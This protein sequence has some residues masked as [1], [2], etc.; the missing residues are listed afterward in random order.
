MEKYEEDYIERLFVAR[1]QGWILAFTAGGHC[2]FLPVLE[3]PESGRASRGQSVYSLLAGADRKDPIVAMLPVGDLTEEEKV[4]VFL[5][6][7]GIIKRTALSEFSNPRS[8]GIIAAGLKEDDRVLDVDLSDGGADVMLL[9]SS[10]R[11]IRFS[12]EDV[13]VQGRTAQGVKGIGLGDDDEAVGM[14]LI[15]REAAVLTVTQDGMGK[16][17][18]VSEFPLQRRGGT[19]T[20]ALPSGGKGSRVVSALEVLPQEEVM[21]ITAGGQVTRVK[22]NDVPVQG[23]RTQGRRMVK[24]KSG[25]RVA[26]VTRAAGDDSPGGGGPG[27]EGRGT[28]AGPDEYAG[29]EEQRELDLLEG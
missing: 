18:P 10:G 13:P 3:I 21:V 20:M 5:S 8:T 16:R 9:T 17:T 23:R 19:G 11:A 27:S 28:G 2:H 26:Q 7:G 24:I 4:V 1:T 29:D 6:K 15:R 12:E 14:L 22:A 25:D